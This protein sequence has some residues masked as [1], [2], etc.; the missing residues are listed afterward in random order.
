M[1]GSNLREKL[2]SKEQMQAIHESLRSQNL[3]LKDVTSLDRLVDGVVEEEGELASREPK[4]SIALPS[5]RR[6]SHLTDLAHAPS[7]QRGRA[8]T[9]R[10]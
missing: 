7:L 2:L 6:T 5:R 3:K 10:S 9:R 8:G 4:R 1:F